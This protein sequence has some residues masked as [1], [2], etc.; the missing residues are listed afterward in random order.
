M[1]WKVSVAR[2]PDRLDAFGWRLERTDVSYHPDEPNKALL[3]WEAKKALG[4]VRWMRNVDPDN[5]RSSGHSYTT[6]NRILGQIAN[7]DAYT[8]VRAAS[9]HDT[10]AWMALYTQHP[11]S[12]AKW[13]GFH[14]TDPYT[15][16]FE[17]HGTT[18]SKGKEQIADVATDLM[19]KLGDLKAG[20]TANFDFYYVFDKTFEDNHF[21][22][23]KPTCSE[24]PIV[25]PPH[26]TTLAAGE[27]GDKPM[28]IV[29]PSHVTSMMVGEEGDTPAPIMPPPYDATSLAVGEEG[30]MPA[31]IMTMAIGEGG[32]GMMK[33]STA[34]VGEE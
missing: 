19:I 16:G 34:A 13:G 25:T 9:N 30:D 2:L 23:I 24:S 11:N 26:V 27:E 20:K 15:S 28:P 3:V 8:A 5:D 31:P 17:Q 12:F 21:S 4:D 29:P 22:G 7:G 14:N 33:A 6:R 10:H 32:G 1:R 18:F